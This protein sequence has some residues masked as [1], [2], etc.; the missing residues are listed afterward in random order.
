MVLT[1]GITKEILAVKS[2]NKKQTKFYASKVD[3]IEKAT[4]SLIS[5]STMSSGETTFSN[6]IH[7]MVINLNSLNDAE[8]VF[9]ELLGIPVHNSNGNNTLNTNE[10]GYRQLMK[11]QLHAELS[12]LR[13]QVPG[14]KGHTDSAYHM[15]RVSDSELRSSYENTMIG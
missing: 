7:P 12:I 15:G 4:L 11:S 9:N 10:L 8:D 14:L 6:S 3:N 1:E 2:L 13:K 5:D